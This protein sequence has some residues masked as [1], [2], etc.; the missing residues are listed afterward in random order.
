L[1][2]ARCC[3]LVQAAAVLLTWS[4]AASLLQQTSPA[5][6]LWLAC[7]SFLG[8]LCMLEV[9]LLLCR[10]IANSPTAGSRSRD[11]L[12]CTRKVNRSA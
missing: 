6:P 10:S 12:M 11:M 9:L 7:C 5:L 4:H 1:A 3:C 2:V 8:Y